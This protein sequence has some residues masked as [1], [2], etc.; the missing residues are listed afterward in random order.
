MFQDI[1]HIGFL[2]D[3]NAAA[4]D[5]YVKTFDAELIGEGLSAGGAKMAFLK[6]GGTEVELIEAPDRVRAAGKGSILLDHVGYLVPDIEAA[7]DAFRSR[8]LK[9]AADK[10]NINPL[11]HKIL[12][13][14]SSTTNGVKMH[15]S[16]R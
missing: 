14:D 5:F 2:T 12:Y 11:G 1:Y 7:A 8:G 4:I 6:M 13:F 9:F 10:P 15:L 3:N 16:E